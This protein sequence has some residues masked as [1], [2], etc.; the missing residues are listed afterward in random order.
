M[1]AFF[2]QL[3]VLTGPKLSYQLTQAQNKIFSEVFKNICTIDT[4]LPRISISIARQIHQKKNK[5][6][7]SGVEPGCKIKMQ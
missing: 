6:L 7:I 3:Q 2:V 1:S 4:T 5:E